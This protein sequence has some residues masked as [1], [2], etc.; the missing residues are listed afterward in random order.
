MHSFEEAARRAVNARSMAS[1]A[2]AMACFVVNDALVKYASQSLP[3]AQLIFLR[4][5]M[6]TVLVLA[7]AHASGA[8]TRISDIARGKVVVRALVD[9]TATMLYLSSLFHLPLGN[10]T[11]IN[12]AAPLVMVAF[13]VIFM[14]ERVNL[15]RWLAL[16]AGF[17]GVLL[18]IQPRAGGF[19]G[20][21]WVCLLGTLFHAT[22]DLL[23]RQIAQNVPSILIT[24]A[25]AASVTIL[26]GIASAVQ[27]WKPF[28]V[29]ELVMLGAASVFLAAGYY[30]IISAMR[31][32]EMSLTAP[33]RYTSLLFALVIGFVVWGEVP[34]FAAWFGIALLLASGLYV[35]QGNFRAPKQNP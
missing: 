10:A 18:I 11:A 6:A 12:L 8:T 32:G 19:N 9:A 33:F 26:S 27:G 3:A 5:V 35:A 1:M 17:A 30:L 2:G 34:N 24:L 7:V 13:A 23:T 4:G 15:Q 29:M 14:G 31:Q 16:L 22:R 25:T 21:A 20:W 28:G